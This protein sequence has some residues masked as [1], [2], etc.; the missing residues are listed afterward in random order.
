MVIRGRE[1]KCEIGNK[2]NV[3]ILRLVLYH[4]KGW[5]RF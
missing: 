1:E 2:L 3:I 5:R 4:G